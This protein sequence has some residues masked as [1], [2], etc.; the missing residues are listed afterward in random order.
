[1]HGLFESANVRKA[2]TQ[3]ANIAEHQTSALSW[4]DHQ[5]NL[6]NNMADLLEAHLDLIPMRRYLDI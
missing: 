6:Y 2:L 1:L 3:L 4:Q 5:Q